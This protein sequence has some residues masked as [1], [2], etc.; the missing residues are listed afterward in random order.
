MDATQDIRQHISTQCG[1]GLQQKSIRSLPQGGAIRRQTGAQPGGNPGGKEAAPDGGGKECAICVQAAKRFRHALRLRAIIFQQSD[2]HGFARA[3]GKTARAGFLRLAQRD[4]SPGKG[5]R[6][7]DQRVS[8]RVRPFTVDYGLDAITSRRKLS[9]CSGAI[10]F[11]C[12]AP[13]SGARRRITRVGDPA[14]P[15][16]EQSRPMSSGPQTRNGSAARRF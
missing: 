11:V 1:P 5:A 13:L 12:R 2:Q 6:P 3:R 15:Q 16:S 14:S 4:D 9:I 8:V 10:H 7:S